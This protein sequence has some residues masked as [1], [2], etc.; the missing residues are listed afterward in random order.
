MISKTMFFICVLAALLVVPFTAHSADVDDLKMA[1]DQLMTSLSQRDADGVGAV[2]HDQTVFF[3]PSSPFPVVGKAA[4]MQRLKSI[5]N[6]L[7]R[8]TFRPID[9]QFSV[10]GN[11]GAVWGYLTVLRKPKG[12]PMNALHLRF[13]ISFV[14][15]GGKWLSLA[16]HASALN[17]GNT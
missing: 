6:S 17:V 13:T 9:P 1:F 12:G 8:L 7:E 16:T 10:V 2:W 3:T 11:T 4:R 5:F 14:K 15:E